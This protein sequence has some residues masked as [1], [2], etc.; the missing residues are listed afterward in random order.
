[1]KELSSPEQPN[2]EETL[3]AVFSDA[4]RA[5]Q[6]PEL[7]DVTDLEKSAEYH[8][9]AEDRVALEREMLLYARERASGGYIPAWMLH[10]DIDHEPVEYD[11]R[12][13]KVH[14]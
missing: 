7:L 6:K 3:D 9:I 14:P 12:D 10:S 8:S 1:M 4:R 11:V 2:R 13:N 5:F